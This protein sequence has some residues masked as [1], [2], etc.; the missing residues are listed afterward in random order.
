MVLKAIQTPT[1]QEAVY[2]E[3]Y[4][5]IVS[6]K[7]S[8][9]ERI[10][11]RQLANDL[12]VS[13]MPVREA[14]R[15]LEAKNFITIHSN[16]QIVVN[17]LSPEHFRQI[18]EARLLLESH[19]AKKASKM[20]SE[21]TIF[22]LEETMKQM[23]E[24]QDEVILMEANRQFHR[25]IYREANLPVFMG[26]IDSL[27]E[28]VSPYFNIISKNEKYWV[29]RAYLKNHVGMLDGMRNKNPQ[30]VHKWLKQDLNEAAE[31]LYAMLDQ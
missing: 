1:V 24:T 6:G 25:I 31:V 3:L 29:E 18:L 22:E 28:R 7:I 12:E 30:E 2:D 26:I 27:W 16:K 11:M 5:A 17:E 8:P 4:Q 10:T 20:R 14:L 21:E 9:G 15:R 19:A 13:V 23:K